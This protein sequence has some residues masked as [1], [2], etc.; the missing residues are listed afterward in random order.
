MITKEQIVELKKNNP[1]GLHTLIQ[2]KADS[3]EIL[4]V[5]EN[6]GYL[7]RGFDAS[8]LVPLLKHSND[9]V[10]LWTVKNL[11]KVTDPR[12]MKLLLESAT[13][14]TDSMVRRE[15]VSSIGRMRNQKA[16]PYLTQLLND[17]DPKI[18]LQAIRGLLVFRA[19][20]PVKEQLKK[21]ATHPNETVQSV[22]R[23]EFF[24]NSNGHEPKEEHAKSPVF[25][26]NVVVQGNV[27]EILKHVPDESIHLTFT[28]PPY[29]N[30]R[31]YSIYESYNA[32]LDF[33]TQV[34]CQVYRVTKEGRFLIVN[35]SPVIVPRVSRAHS[36]K[37]Y[38]IPFDLHARLVQNGWEFIDD[39]I[40][41]KP[42]T[43][44]KNRNAGF[45]QHRKPLGYKPNPTTEY[46]MVYRKQ[47]DKLLDWN[48]RAYEWNTVQESR[49]QGGYETSNVW[50]ID[51]TFDK[52]HSAVFPVELCNRVIT[53]YSYKG[54]LVFD[55]FAGS[56][57]LGRA[58]RN[59]GRFF[60][61]TEQ[62]RK[63]V[64]RMKQDLVEKDLF[65]NETRFL[66][67][68]QF[69]DLSSRTKPTD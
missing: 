52:V 31:D 64:E 40:W 44:V 29:Y 3:R 33:L 10:R 6:L 59:L 19:N 50:K 53:F 35:T 39:I 48:M 20:L 42:E 32:Y 17:S 13:Q 43:S 7:P 30:A 57:T 1:S 24:Q 34:F 49:V 4:F 66:T 38:P 9:Q 67:L 11:G 36:S 46:L 12:F 47:T 61:L 2:Q 14:D 62:E 16:I 41:L 69:A 28:S 37:R 22:I 68:E 21:L 65:G 26:Q 15:A 23:K 58:A 8:V 5:L 25:M 56:G 18:V 55:P 27:Q 51:P 45:L 60:F 63:Y 54:D